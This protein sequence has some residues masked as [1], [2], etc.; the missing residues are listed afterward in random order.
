MVF[1]KNC[2]NPGKCLPRNPEEY[3]DFAKIRKIGEIGILTSLNLADNILIYNVS[4]CAK[5]HVNCSKN[6]EVIS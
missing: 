4:A 2:Q 1:H 5:F 6:A 3:P